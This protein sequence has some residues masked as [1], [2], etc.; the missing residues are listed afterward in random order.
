MQILRMVPLLLAAVVALPLHAETDDRARVT[1]LADR[2]VAEYEKN[3]PLSFAF[4]GLPVK[5]N[6]GL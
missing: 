3:F 1:A 5:R 6:D 2:F 4:S